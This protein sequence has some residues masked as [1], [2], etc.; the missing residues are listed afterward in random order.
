MEATEALLPPCLLETLT[1]EIRQ[2]SM[3]VFEITYMNT[4]N[5]EDRYFCNNRKRF[6]YL[7]KVPMFSNKYL[8]SV[9][10]VQC[11]LNNELRAT[12]RT[13]RHT[14]YTQPLCYSVQEAPCLPDH[15]LD[16]FFFIYIFL[17]L[18]IL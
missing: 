18:E 6:I 7:E 17:L 4:N 11:L 13:Q 3:C 5:Q 1:R 10:S 2:V 15:F 16:C 8:L 9:S 12:I 14:E